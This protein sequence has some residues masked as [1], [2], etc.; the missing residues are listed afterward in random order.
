MQEFDTPTLEAYLAYPEELRSV[1]RI[2]VFRDFLLS[3][4]AAWH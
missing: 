1:R 2:Q 3:K 4:V